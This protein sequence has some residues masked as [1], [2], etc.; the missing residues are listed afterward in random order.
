MH[1]NPQHLG[2]HNDIRL[3]FYYVLYGLRETN[4]GLKV[5]FKDIFIIQHSPIKIGDMHSKLQNVQNKIYK[6]KQTYTNKPYKITYKTIRK[7]TKRKLRRKTI[8]W[9]VS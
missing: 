7:S 1:C 9:L 4:S 6:L 8:T 5:R 2:Y 3:I